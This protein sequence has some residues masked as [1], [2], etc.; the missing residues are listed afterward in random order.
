MTGQVGTELMPLHFT[1]IHSTNVAL[2]LLF[3]LSGCLILDPGPSE[4]TPIVAE[5]SGDTD[6]TSDVGGDINTDIFTSDLPVDPSLG[7]R[8]SGSPLEDPALD[9][10]LEDVF[11]DVSPSDPT[12]LD[13]SDVS[14]SDS[15]QLD[16]DAIGDQT[17]GMPDDFGDEE[18]GGSEG[19]PCVDE[20]DCPFE[21][22]FCIDV[23]GACH[24]GS[25]GDPCDD[26]D[27]CPGTG[28]DCIDV[29]GDWTCQCV[30]HWTGE[31]CQFCPEHADPANDCLTCMHGWT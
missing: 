30:G 12:D 1:P 3:A 25:V 10:P 28:N 26:E 9:S 7:D 8:V 4:P 16:G 18:I 31:H 15:S 19:D 6:T 2:L 23:D 29:E 20:G 17:D 11:L 13:G 5:T 22:P 14:D 21:A 27:D 24:D